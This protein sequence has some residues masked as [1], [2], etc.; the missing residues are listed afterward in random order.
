[1]RSKYHNYTFFDELNDICIEQGLNYINFND[2]YKVLSKAPFGFMLTADFDGHTVYAERK[3]GTGE[4]Y[5]HNGIDNTDGYLKGQTPTFFLSPWR[6]V[7]NDYQAIAKDSR[8]FIPIIHGGEEPGIVLA[9]YINN[10]NDNI[11]INED[12]NDYINNYNGWSVI[13]NNGYNNKSYDLEVE[14]SMIMQQ[15]NDK[16]YLHKFNFIKDIQNEEETVFFKAQFEK[17]K[18][19]KSPKRNKTN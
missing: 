14:M 4:P 1:M 6:W 11:D 17:T 16:F 10:S 5:S 12:L 7:E 13:G 19:Q 18:V 3:K 8:R 9:M 2:H 15:K